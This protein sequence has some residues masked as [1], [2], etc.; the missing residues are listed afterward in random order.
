MIAESLLIGHEK[1]WAAL[2]R[3]F[4]KG[5][6]PQSLLISG[7]PQ[8]GK[9]TLARRYTQLLLCPNTAP[10]ADALPAPCGHCKV[11]HQ[12]EIE[13]FPDFRVYRPIVAAAK[14]EKDWIVAPAALA[15]SIITVEMA[16]R[17]GEEAMRKPMIGPRKVMV[18]NQAERMN[19]E[20]QNALLKTFEEPVRGLS[21]VLLCDNPSELLPTVR[22]RCWHLPLGLVPDGAI[23][24]WLRDGFQDAPPSLVDEAVHVAAGRPGAA[25]RELQRLRRVRTASPAEKSEAD[26]NGAVES[27][28]AQ[29]MAI[30]DRIARSQP[31]GALGLTE[32]ALRLARQW[33]AEDHAGESAKDAKKSDAK[34][35]R[36]ALARFLDELANAH[37]AKWTSSV[38][39]TPEENRQS[40]TENR[41]WADGLDLIRKTRHYILRNA[42][43]NLALD[44]LFSQLI[45]LQSA[46]SGSLHNGSKPPGGMT[47]EAVRR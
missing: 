23:A 21:I 6:V 15:G 22:S 2:A 20:A 17:F 30:V 38:A 28:F 41:A 42:N 3:A 4:D 24:A 19:I 31:V 46:A 11:C 36:S 29:A 18:I 13:T 25:R 44:V 34:V 1:R 40:G 32:E 26:G 14:D 7:P 47:V 43:S 45:A 33:W 9:W 39:S 12:V 5:T 16:R 27:R 8:I 35:L 10:G 37:R